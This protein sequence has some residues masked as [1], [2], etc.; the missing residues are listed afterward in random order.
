MAAA[1]VL[2]ETFAS[3]S[4][5]IKVRFVVRIQKYDFRKRYFFFIKNR[6][7]RSYQPCY[8]SFKKPMIF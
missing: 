4:V 3:N 8:K 5:S 6:T 2:I 1:W 7:L